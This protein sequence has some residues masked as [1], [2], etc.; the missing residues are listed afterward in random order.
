MNI[1]KRHFGK[2]ASAIAAT[3]LL[4]QVQ[5]AN[6]TPGSYSSFAVGK[7]IYSKNIGYQ[8][9]FPIV[10]VG[11]PPASTI[12]NIGYSWGLS[13]YPAG[14]VVYLCHGS[15][16]ACLDITNSRSGTTSVFNSRNPQIPFFLY[17]YVNGSGTMSPAYGENNNVIVNWD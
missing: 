9:D 12:N 2:L 6:A 3:A 14:L 5:P 16:S 1:T 11:T 13:Y 17:Y 15:T 8:T 7:T 10:W 4:A